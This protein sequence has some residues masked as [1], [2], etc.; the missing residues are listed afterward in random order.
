M[1]ATICSRIRYERWTNL[2]YPKNADMWFHFA[3]TSLS[4]HES[5]P[6]FSIQR[7]ENV[8]CT[9]IAVFMKGVL[10]ISIVSVNNTTRNINMPKS[11]PPT[12][13]YHAIC[14]FHPT[15]ARWDTPTHNPWELPSWTCCF[16]SNLDCMYNLKIIQPWIRNKIIK[17][18][19]CM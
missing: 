18:V 6:V 13:I 19:F 3:A 16:R 9:R 2:R 7:R 5:H 1:G 15:P 10:D 4:F 17:K 12:R 14:E 8:S 11:M